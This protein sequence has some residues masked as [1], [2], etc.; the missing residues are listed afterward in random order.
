MTSVRLL[1]FYLTVCA[2]SAQQRG[3]RDGLG[4]H[5]PVSKACAH[6]AEKTV[7]NVGGERRGAPTGLRQVSEGRKLYNVEWAEWRK[8]IPE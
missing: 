3:R 1:L 4:K 6:E 7:D 5:P 8:N 2:L